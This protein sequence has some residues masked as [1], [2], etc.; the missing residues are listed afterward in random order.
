MNR[1]TVDIICMYM[2]RLCTGLIIISWNTPE[3]HIEPIAGDVNDDNFFI[4]YSRKYQQ[5][6]TKSHSKLPFNITLHS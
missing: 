1:P 5:K 6:F 2:Y 3:M 4:Y